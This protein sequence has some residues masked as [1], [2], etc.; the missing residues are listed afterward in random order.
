MA[1]LKGSNFEK[2]IR[3]ANF[4]LAAFGEKRHGTNSHLTH[5]DSLRVKRDSYLKIC[6]RTGTRRQVE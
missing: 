3:D 6:S 5:S 1:N 4:R 2:Q